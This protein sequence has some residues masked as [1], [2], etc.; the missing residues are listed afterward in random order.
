M[1]N[2]N[3]IRTSTSLP[4]QAEVDDRPSGVT[5]SAARDPG[6][7]YRPAGATEGFR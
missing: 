2:T 7:A 1:V 4:V 6:K 3:G 5:G